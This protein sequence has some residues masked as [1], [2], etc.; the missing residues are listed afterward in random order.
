VDR[1]LLDQ[2]YT[3]HLAQ[4][5]RGY[6]SILAASGYDAV[7]IHSGCPKPRSVFDDQY[8]PL[9]VT[10]HFQHWLPLAEADCALVIAP[11]RQPRL[12]WM[13]D[14]SFWEKPAP[15]EA[16]HWQV[17]FEIVL[18]EALEAIKAEL[19]TG[20]VAF[21]GEERGRAA[22]WGFADAAVAPKELVEQLDQLRVRKSDYE[23]LCLAEAN[24]RAALGHQA[25]AA[26]FRSGDASELELHLL[27]LSATGQDD[28]ETPY[29]NIVAL[30]ENAATL[31][32]VSY[33]KSKTPGVGA[34]SMLVDAG[35]AYLGYCSDITRT[36]V[37]GSGA[38]ASAFAQLVARVESF[39][40]RLCSEVS[41]GEKYESLHDQ[42]HRD[43]A[44]A[45]REAGVTTL[46]VDEAIS[47]GI[48][49]TFFPHG[50][51]HSLG[52]QCHDVGCALIKPR[53]DNPFLRNTTLVAERQ[54]FTI[55]PGIYFIST[56]LDKLKQG[57]H[58]ASIDW[59]LV[60]ELAQLGGVRI[61]DDLVVVSGQPSTR[62]L[63]R[64][65]LA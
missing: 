9:R 36:H 24:R 18:V 31:H 27:Y 61:E 19:P 25:L 28:P 12:I 45:L 39:Q 17:H 1:A 29:K 30:G 3:G 54:C 64:E 13:Q 26:A 40:Q 57:A 16:Q 44:A 23:V 37:K 5:E 55:E 32:H 33:R 56:L 14:Q 11:G 38:A 52:L 42:A 51:G 53:P 62:N 21:I 35:A 58:A 43:V 4:L 47:G 8:W 49:R 6:A 46:S 48:T 10:P 59:T 20:R 60:G 2:L 34:Q 7:V 15:L 41:V 50:L 65:V 22:S 63:T